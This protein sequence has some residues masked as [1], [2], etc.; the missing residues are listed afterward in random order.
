MTTGSV[1]G[2]VQ[3]RGK[4]PGVRRWDYHQPWRIPFLKYNSLHID[5]PSS[6][7]TKGLHF[8]K[9][10]LCC[11]W[12]ICNPRQASHGL[13]KPRSK[14]LFL[15][16]CLRTK[17][18]NT[19]DKS[20]QFCQK[21]R[22]SLKSNRL[23]IWE[24][25]L[26]ITFQITLEINPRRNIWRLRSGKHDRALSLTWISERSIIQIIIYMEVNCKTVS[27][28]EKHCSSHQGNAGW[29]SGCEQCEC[30]S[31]FV[32]KTVFTARQTEARQMRTFNIG[33]GNQWDRRLRLDPPSYLL[34]AVFFWFWSA[35]HWAG[36]GQSLVHK[37]GAN[38]LFCQFHPI[39][40]TKLSNHQPP[41]GAAV[42]RLQPWRTELVIWNSRT[43]ARVMD[44][45]RNRH[46]ALIP[47]G[48]ISKFQLLISLLDV[49]WRGWPSQT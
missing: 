47:F 39:P 30:F 37:I 15:V 16:A 40:V 31:G 35:E 14:V 19:G 44:R 46:P 22:E 13:L 45:R 10:T 18:T 17:K 12:A 7:G 41:R 28:A 1:H 42:G 2:G 3:A 43:Q 27:G 24:R 11:F 36:K 5:W 4:P 20:F 9:P 21:E 26:L 8:S 23:I 25:Q 34:G 48:L 49:R 29:F 32:I 6:E 33:T 38:H